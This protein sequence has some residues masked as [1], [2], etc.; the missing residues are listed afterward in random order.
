[1][2]YHVGRDRKNRIRPYY[3]IVARSRGKNPRWHWHVRRH[4]DNSTAFRGAGKGFD[5][6]RAAVDDLKRVTWQLERM[7]MQVRDQ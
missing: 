6:E 1:M 7:T 3:A 4:A 5:S 2:S